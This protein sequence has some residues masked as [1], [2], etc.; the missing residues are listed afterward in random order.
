VPTKTPLSSTDQGRVCQVADTSGLYDNFFNELIYKG[1]QDSHGIYGWDI[2]ALPS[3]SNSDADK[4]YAEFLRGDCDLIIGAGTTS[5]ALRA[6]ALTDPNQ[7]FLLPDV[8]F[9]EPMENLWTQ[10]YATDQAAFLA[11]YIAASVTR[12]GKVGL[13]GGVDLLPVTDF[14]DGFVLGVQYYDDKHGTNIEALGWDV[15]KREGL[16]VGS[17]CCAAEGRMITGELLDAGA[18]I[19]LPV[20]GTEVGL[21][22]LSAAQ[23]H[24][25]AYIIGVDIDWAVSEPMYADLILTSILKNLNV[26]VV[27]AVKTIEEGTFTGGIHIGTL[28]TGEVGL[29]SF[30]E[31]DSLVSDQVKADLEQIKKDIIAGRIKTKP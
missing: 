31:L 3:A 10:I 13:F 1:L 2:Q 14:M 21:G 18:D 6:A 28:E 19:V 27:R 24:D 12:T 29:A 15:E 23:S 5:D 11:G 26:T 20:A 9:D 7:N 8:V 22:S 30:H 25:N 4:N 17:F 16:F